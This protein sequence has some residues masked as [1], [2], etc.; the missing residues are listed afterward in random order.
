MMKHSIFIMKPSSKL[1]LAS[2]FVMLCA[3]PH[4]LF[5]A[6]QAAAPA[7]TFTYNKEASERLEILLRTIDHDQNFGKNTY[8]QYRSEIK[9]L[10]GNKDADPTLPRG[11]LIGILGEA[12]C[13]KDAEMVRK[14]LKHGANPNEPCGYGDKGYL[15]P[16][17]FASS[18]EIARLLIHKG[19]TIPKNIL[20][21][22]GT[23]G[24]P[25]NM[26]AFFGNAGATI[27]S[28]EILLR[29]FDSGWSTD[30]KTAILLWFNANHDVP[31][32]RDF[33]RQ[34]FRFGHIVFSADQVRNKNLHYNKWIE[35]LNLLKQVVPAT[36]NSK[37]ENLLAPHIS[38]DPAVIVREYMGPLHIPWDDS[39]FSEIEQRMK[40]IEIARGKAARK[41]AK[42]NTTECS[43]C[44]VS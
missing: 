24:K 28:P 30:E 9:D 42:R 20:A 22:N 14:C 15:T 23:T 36:K 1:F 13:R 7:K 34:K 21:F 11:R 10:I 32:S 29:L 5:A 31:L 33:T 8:P 40:Q 43:T 16:L 18:V 19:A 41:V 26:L 35:R 4:D 2:M 17:E 27:H 39:C 6:E 44:S 37:I 3:V 12:I 25:A 38:K